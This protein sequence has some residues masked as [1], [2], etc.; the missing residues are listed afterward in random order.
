MLNGP[1]V[2]STHRLPF[3]VAVPVHAK[4]DGEEAVH[5]WTIA[6]GT[7]RQLME[8]F[9]PGVDL[10]D[11][12][13]DGEVVNFTV[14]SEKTV[15]EDGKK[16]ASLSRLI[17]TA[18]RSTDALKKPMRT[19]IAIDI[20]EFE[21]IEVED[22]LHIVVSVKDFRAITQH[23]GIGGSEL[24]AKYSLPSRPVRLSYHGDGISCE[25]LLMAIGERGE[26]G[27]KTKRSK[28]NGMKPPRQ[29]L[30]PA[31]RR[32]SAAP[33]EPPQPPEQTHQPPPSRAPLAPPPR[34]SISVPRVSHF[35]LRP[36]QRPVPAP[37][38]N[39]DSLFVDNDQ[40][41]EPVR[42]E[43]DE[44]EEDNARLEWGNSNQPVSAATN[45]DLNCSPL[46]SLVQLWPDNESGDGR[47]ER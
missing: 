38:L 36:S 5:H 41:W 23:A 32:Q 12:N 18:Y 24:S 27:K 37:T 3:E 43:D 22:K 47:A 10:I 34:P 2:S 45:T 16:A 9:G 46:I 4:F 33:S 15:K 11:I 1:G 7:L 14:Y 30:A 42:D 19:S 26:L 39:S 31:S 44:E 21:D 28:A 13:A 6:S 25:F 8:H 17:I 40:D 29:E 35:D 20:D